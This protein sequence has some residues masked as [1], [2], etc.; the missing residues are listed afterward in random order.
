M[1]NAVRL[2]AVWG[3]AC[4]LALP[5]AN[6]QEGGGFQPPLNAEP[7][8]PIPTGQA[9]QPGFYTSAEFVLRSSRA[10][11]TESNPRL[12]PPKAPP[13]P[14]EHLGEYLIA[15]RLPC[16]TLP[17]AQAQL[18]TTSTPLPPWEEPRPRRISVYRGGDYRGADGDGPVR[19]ELGAL[20]PKPGEN[21][22]EYA[23]ASELPPH[24]PAPE[25]KL[26]TTIPLP[27]R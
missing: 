19:P 6:A 15:D 3:L 24:Y 27:P 17:L 26:P 12:K 22:G 20:P 7:V 13:K 25:T 2:V 1:R 5:Q 18:P 4:L 23:L 14:G 9:G 8:I 10:I 11:G 16:Q 21:F